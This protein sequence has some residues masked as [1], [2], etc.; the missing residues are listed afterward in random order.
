M[1]FYA[2]QAF[3]D[4]PGGLQERCGWS[5][6]QAPGW[7]QV[8]RPPPPVDGPAFL[9]RR[10]LYRRQAAA[11]LSVQAA[12]AV[13]FAIAGTRLLLDGQLM[14]AMLAALSALLATLATWAI[15]FHFHI[16]SQFREAFFAACCAVYWSVAAFVG[17]QEG[18]TRLLECP[19]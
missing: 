12:G 17:K 4:K 3:A 9:C 6:L 8:R 19:L 13:M 11:D 16:W 2:C 1:P 7:A 10:L 14:G 15:T 5:A 18:N